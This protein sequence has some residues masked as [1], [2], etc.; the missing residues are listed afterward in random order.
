MKLPAGQP[1][2][3]FAGWITQDAG[4]KLLALSGKTVDEML[5]A[6]NSRDFKPIPLGI[7]IRANIPTR[8]PADSVQQRDR[9]SG[10]QRPAAQIA[11]RD[12]HRALGS[13]GNRPGCQWRHHL[14]WRRGQCHRLRHD[15]RD[16]ARLGR[17]GAQ[18][19][20]VGG[21]HGGDGRRSRVAAGASIT[22]SIR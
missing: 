3:A 12:L 10:G 8:D 20:T 4:A 5:K 11:S 22:P 17:A 19:E 13:F 18:A 21:V 14:Q 15:Y 2:L 9:E 1:A 16:G 6:A 7:H